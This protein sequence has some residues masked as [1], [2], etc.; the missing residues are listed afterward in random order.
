MNILEVMREVE[1]K[2]EVE[3][4]SFVVFVLIAIG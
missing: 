2:V 4:A 3:H 1:V